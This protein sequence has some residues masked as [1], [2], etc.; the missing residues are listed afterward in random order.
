MYL[1]PTSYVRNNILLSFQYI[2]LS[3]D[4]RPDLVLTLLLREWGLEKPKLLI[5]VNGGK[6]NFELQPRLK[7]NLGRGLLKAAKTTGA[8]YDDRSISQMKNGFLFFLSFQDLH[9]WHQHWGDQARG[10]RPRHREEPKDQRRVQ[11]FLSAKPNFFLL[12]T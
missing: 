9:R 3:Y 11:T 6:A 10:G 4:T 7:R 2:R 12:F 1:V 8:W 5:T